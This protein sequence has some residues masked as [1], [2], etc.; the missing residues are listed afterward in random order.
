M[1]WCLCIR[2]CLESLEVHVSCKR[3]AR[4]SDHH[5]CQLLSVVEYFLF[6]FFVV[7]AKCLCWPGDVHVGGSSALCPGFYPHGQGV[8][9]GLQQPQMVYG[10]RE[11]VGLDNTITSLDAFFI[12]LLTEVWDNNLFTWFNLFYLPERQWKCNSKFAKDKR[13]MTTEHHYSSRNN[14]NL[15]LC[16]IWYHD[17]VIL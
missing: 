12:C 16:V 5:L 17:D 2:T 10:L 1:R 8:E 13:L 9:T 7:Q 4:G 14:S 3:S 15:H 6:F 11:E